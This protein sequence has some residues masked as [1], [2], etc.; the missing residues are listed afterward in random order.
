MYPHVV[1]F[2]TKSLQFELTSRLRR[3]R[4]QARAGTHAGRP[5]LLA[6]IVSVR[7]K[8]GVGGTTATSER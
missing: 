1:Q 8:R 6:R 4:R 7:E 3:E 2:E 5:S